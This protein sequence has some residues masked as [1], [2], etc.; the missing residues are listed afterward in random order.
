MSTLHITDETVIHQA[1]VLAKLH[2][3]TVEQ[4]VKETMEQAFRAET[5]FQERARRADPAKALAILDRMG[6]G[7]PPDPGDELPEGWAARE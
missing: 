5:Y 2:G 1:E 6:I 7:N 4:I 3:V